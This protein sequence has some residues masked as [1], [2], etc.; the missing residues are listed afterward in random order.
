[1]YQPHDVV[2]YST[3]SK[4]QT[5]GRSASTHVS[6]WCCKELEM[7]LSPISTLLL[8]IIVGCVVTTLIHSLTVSC[9]QCGGSSSRSLIGLSSIYTSNDRFRVHQLGMMASDSSCASLRL[10]LETVKTAPASASSTRRRKRNSDDAKGIVDS[11]YC[12]YIKILAPRSFL[13]LLLS[14]C[15]L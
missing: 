3:T 2:R 5:A 6:C 7:T 9:V 10:Q 11:K 15:L 8:G 14:V 4:E 1:M 13:Q 12:T